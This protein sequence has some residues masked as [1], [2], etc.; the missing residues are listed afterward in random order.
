MEIKT[1]NELDKQ[2]F[3]NE[4]KTHL[5]EINKIPKT[6]GFIKS[7]NVIYVLI[8]PQPGQVRGDW[9]VHIN[10][11]IHSN[12]R[13]KIK[14]IN[15]AKKIA[16]KYKSTV[17]VQNINGLFNKSFKPREKKLNKSF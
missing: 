17:M 3:I 1:Y 11:K 16:R 7:S 4:I 14:A 10:D 9:S 15:E 12:H 5:K 8:N 2:C 6:D 13:T